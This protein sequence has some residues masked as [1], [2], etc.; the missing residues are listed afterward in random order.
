MLMM[1]EYQHLVAVLVIRVDHIPIVVIPD[2]FQ[3]DVQLL[4]G[5]LRMN[6]DVMIIAIHL[7]NI[8][9]ALILE[10]LSQMI[11]LA[12]GHLVELPKVQTV[13]KMYS[14]ITVKC[15]VWTV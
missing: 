4:R 5:A 10:T 15:I 7:A 1:T 14:T 3:E 2:P 11:A 6:K 9:L 12:Q 13:T 8:Q